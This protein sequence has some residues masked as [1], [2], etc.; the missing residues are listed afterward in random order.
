MTYCDNKVVIIGD[1]DVGKSTIMLWALQ[2]KFIRNIESTVGA[3]FGVKEFNISGQKVK[4]N[5]WDT[6]GQE[7]FRSITPLYYK[8]TMGCICVFDVTNR[9]T[10]NNLGFW[11]KQYDDCNHAHNATIIILANKCDKDYSLWEVSKKEIENY[12]LINSIEVIY[13]NCITGDNIQ[14]AFNKLAKNAIDNKK[15]QLIETAEKV[16]TT[17]FIGMVDLDSLKQDDYCS[18]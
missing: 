8:N 4:L 17:N 6:A 12:A 3:S 14:E 13:T 7:R 15:N 16:K 9:K 1:S 11:I 2:N 10:F 5:I 18:C